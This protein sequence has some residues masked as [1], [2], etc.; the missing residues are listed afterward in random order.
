MA[1]AWGIVVE[2][3]VSPVHGLTPLANLPYAISGPGSRSRDMR[4]TRNRGNR[5]FRRP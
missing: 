4:G 1:G 2:V 3:L 5:C